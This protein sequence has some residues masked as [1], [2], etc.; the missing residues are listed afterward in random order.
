MPLIY[1]QVLCFIE[2]KNC[3]KNQ[4]T[5]KDINTY[6]FLM[7]FSYSTRLLPH[8]RENTQ[9]KETKKEANRTQFHRDA[10]I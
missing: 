3:N 1:D 2:K 6:H 9:K 5:P 4:S 8:K 7:Q 10:F